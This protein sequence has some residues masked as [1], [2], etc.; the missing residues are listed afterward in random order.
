MDFKF[1][2]PRQALVQQLLQKGIQ[3]IRVLDAINQVERHH[4]IQSAMHPRAYE[5]TALPIGKEQTISQP[6]TVARQT[7]L[8]GVKEGDNVL[9]IGTGSGYQAAVLAQMG[10]KV[11]SVERHAE[12]SHQ[13]R[14]IL[15][16]LGYRVKFRIGDGT[17]GWNAFAPFDAIL[18]TAGAPDV[19]KDLLWQLH[20]GGR[21]VIPVGDREKQRMYRITRISE[22]EFERENFGGFKFVPLIGQQ[23]W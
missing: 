15:Q 20:L 16:Q 1:I 14:S 8:L 13:A 4:F 2:K 10:C 11:H 23:G 9:E 21:L 17:R 18:V 6:Y 7:E 3:D 19:P 5:D 12:L 22:E